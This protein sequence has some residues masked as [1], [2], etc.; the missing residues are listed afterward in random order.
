[1]TLGAASERQRAGHPG[2]QRASKGWRLAA[3]AAGLLV[4]AGIALFLLGD[5]LTSDDDGSS[6]AS[7]GAL[8]RVVEDAVPASEPFPRLTETTIRVGDE[9]MLVVV[10]D[11]D[12]ERYRGL[13]G[14]EDV[15]GYDGMLFVFDVA[16]ARLRSRCRPCARRS[17]SASTTPTGTSSTACACS[18][19][20]SPRRGVPLYRAARRVHV[21]DRDPPRR[22]PERGRVRVTSHRGASMVD[23]FRV[24]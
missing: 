12:Q 4:V 10:A 23:R 21:R 17:T 18:R 9:T 1:M 8:S 3:V 13:R 15:G 19:A 7:S 22:P 5:A 14:R 24:E 6:P 20:G 11:D 2:S 16:H